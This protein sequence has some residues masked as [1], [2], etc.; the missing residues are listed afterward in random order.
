MTAYYNEFD[1]KAAAWLR[2]LIRRGLLP[3]GEVDERSI[4]DVSADDLVGF[5]QC[6]FFAGI[7]G[8]PYALRLAGWQDDWPVWTGSPPCQPFSAAGQQKGQAD[9]RH[10]APHFAALVAAGRPPILFGEQVAS[11]AV[12]GKAAKRAGGGAGEPPEWAWIDDLSDRLE[13]A[14]YAVGAADIPAAGVGAPHIRQRTFFGAVRLADA[15]YMPGRHWSKSNEEKQHA[16]ARRSDGVRGLADPASTGL[17]G[18]CNP[19][20]AASR[21][22]LNRRIGICSEGCADD[23]MA[24]ADEGERRRVADGE[25]RQHDGEAGG[26]QQGDRE[27]ERGGSGVGMADSAGG[28]HRNGEEQPSG[29]HGLQP[30]GRGAERQGRGGPQHSRPDGLGRD[31]PS[32]DHGGWTDA[33]WLFCRD[34]KWRPV[35]P[36]TFPL[37]HGIPARVVRLRG[38]GNAIVPQAAAQFIAAFVAACKMEQSQ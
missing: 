26:R 11:S 31:W 18:Q 12:F 28:Q 5:T 15:G 8:W 17:E 14:H 32:A 29:Q 27:P 34:G 21:D 13:A 38:Y 2:E 35:E 30:Q 23:G 33:D 22:D 4:L 19:G 20:G 36:G 37:A 3:A 9:D 24:D 16:A 7:G 1:P 6:H 10:L 25:G